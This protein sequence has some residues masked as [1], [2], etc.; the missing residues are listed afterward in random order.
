MLLALAA[1]MTAAP[2]AAQRA[3]LRP[4]DRAVIRILGLH[5]ENAVSVGTGFFVTNDG[6]V[7]TAAHVVTDAR[8]LLGI[9][10]ANG[11]SFRL[12][13][14]VLDESHDVAILQAVGVTPP[15]I[16]PLDGDLPAVTGGDQVSISGYS[17]GEMRE[18]APAVT[19]GHISRSLSDGSM[20]LSASVNPGQSGGPVL[21]ADGTLLGLVSARADPA[22]G[23]IGMTLVRPREEIRTAFAAA[24]PLAGAVASSELTRLLA[25]RAGAMVLPTLTLAEVEAALDAARTAHEYANVLVAAR[26]YIDP[27]ETRV[28]EIEALVRTRARSLVERY[29]QLLVLYP[30]LARAVVDA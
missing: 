19:I 20:E 29:P 4:A 21:A 12:I 23:V 5:A 15:A 9:A 25:F 27:P 11:E 14:R 22:S 2:L 17:G 6:W 3:S 1:T 16:L 7:V 28:R 13:L 24:T 8:V 26:I 10:A 18:L 30:T